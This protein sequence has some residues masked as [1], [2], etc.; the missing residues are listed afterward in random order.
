MA[1]APTAD[2]DYLVQVK[3]PNMTGSGILIAADLVLCCEH[4]LGGRKT[5]TVLAGGTSITA[6]VEAPDKKNDLA[7]LRLS[8]PVP[9]YR[10]LV[11]LANMRRGETVRLRGYGPIEVVSGD[12][13]V[14]P[15]RHIEAERRVLS[16]DLDPAALEGMSG[17]AAL[18]PIC[19]EDF[20]VGLIRK[21]GEDAYKSIVIGEGTI[22]RFLA[23]R[24]TLPLHPVRP[25]AP[26]TPP[27]PALYFKSLAEDCGFIRPVGQA[28]AGRVPIARVFIPLRATGHGDEGR[29]PTLL[30]AVAKSRSVLITGS[31]G[32]GKTTFVRRLALALSPGQPVDSR[33]KAP[34][35]GFPLYFRVADLERHI[36]TSD[37]KPYTSFS[38]PRWIA[39]YFASRAHKLDTGFFED[40]LDDPNTLLLL[41]GL[42]EASN[43]QRRAD[44]AHLLRHAALMARCRFVVTSRPEAFQKD[45]HLPDFAHAAIADLND[46]EI[47]AFLR[48]WYRSLHADQEG[49]ADEAANRLVKDIGTSRPEILRLARNPLML[50]LLAVVHWNN[51]KLPEGRAELYLRV[52]E[53]LAEWAKDGDHPCPTKDRLRRLSKLAFGMQSGFGKRGSGQKLLVDL[54]DAALCIQSEFASHRPVEDAKEFLEREQGASGVLTLEHGRLR[55]WHRSFQEFLAAKHLD[56]SSPKDIRNAVKFLYVPEWREP[57]QLLAGLWGGD[58]RGRL[59]DLLTMLISSAGKQ[60]LPRKACG[61]GIIGAVLADLGPRG[62]QLPRDAQGPYERILQ[63]VMAIFELGAYKRIGIRDRIAAADALAL[64]RDP[65]LCTP[66]DDGYWVR[67]EPDKFMMGEGS[68]AR[69]VEISKPFDIGRFPVTVWEYQQYLDESAAEPPYEWEDQRKHPSR[70]VNWIG[71]DRAVAYCQW[72]R[73]CRLPTEEEWEFA[74]RGPES[75]LHPWGPEPAD[76][77]RANFADAI[78]EATPVGLYP[79]GNTPN[80]ICDLSGNVWEWTQTEHADGHV[81]KGGAYWVDHDMMRAAYRVGSLDDDFDDVDGFRCVREVFP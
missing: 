20:C 40:K 35:Q 32:S 43:E 24:A 17:G 72:F 13:V 19:G 51:R 64:A 11:W 42:D 21:G 79:E 23:G 68:K 54:G 16:F 80:G 34:F 6:A 1:P 31:A 48:D 36:A 78:G 56:G 29:D 81:V 28:K 70:P 22:S 9:H 26:R 63:D 76:E 50:T 61:V 74:A 59:D 73:G 66:R 25:V 57:I 62:Y 38:D 2:T 8:Q 7:L 52:T 10:P 3:T 53:Y 39:H 30:E 4:E 18:V 12:G 49:A 58:S 15:V 33:F 45:V 37:G 5:A 77:S 44:L 41:D 46:A 71:Y 60:K 67:I 14:G 47:A 27:D 65:G 55:F 75:R 69:E